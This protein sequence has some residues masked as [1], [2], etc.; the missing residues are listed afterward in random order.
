MLI[1]T[2]HQQI[3]ALILIYLKALIRVRIFSVFLINFSAGVSQEDLLSQICHSGSFASIKSLQCWE[4]PCSIGVKRL[5]H[6]YVHKWGFP[7]TKEGGFYNTGTTWKHHSW[8]TRNVGETRIRISS[9]ELLVL[10]RVLNFPG[11]CSCKGM[12]L[13]FPSF[14]KNIPNAH[15]LSVQ[16]LKQS[17]VQIEN[18]GLGTWTKW[19]MWGFPK[20]LLF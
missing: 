16:G 14:P 19:K 20:I 8:K 4:Q 12:S 2:P 17:L 10:F 11:S 3:Q 1:L 18:A 15:N 13:K 7:S 5:Y 9:T 6:L